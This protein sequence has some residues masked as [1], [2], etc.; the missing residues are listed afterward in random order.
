MTHLF[1]NA[2][3]IYSGNCRTGPL[4]LGSDWTGYFIRG[5]DALEIAKRARWLDEVAVDNPLVSTFL[6]ALADSLESC[7][8]PE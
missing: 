7:R 2:S 5:D 1:P 8:E 4:K 6:C 3:D